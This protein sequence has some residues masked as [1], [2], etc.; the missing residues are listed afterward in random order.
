MAVGCPN[1]AFLFNTG[2][3]FALTSEIYNVSMAAIFVFKAVNFVKIDISKS[4]I[5]CMKF[6]Y[7]RASRL[8]IMIF[9]V[10]ADMFG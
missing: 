5:R 3:C 6:M 1:F 8:V 4:Q 9:M 10:N 7:N 2:F